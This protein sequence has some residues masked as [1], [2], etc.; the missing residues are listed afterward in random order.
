M[1]DERDIIGPQEYDPW[2]DET[3]TPGFEELGPSHYGWDG[4]PIT[5]RRWA[6]ERLYRPPHVAEEF[7]HVRDGIRFWISTVWI[8]IDHGHRWIGDPNY[9]P[10][11]FETMIFTTT[12]RWNSVFAEING[13]DLQWR[14]ATKEQALHGHTRLAGALRGGWLPDEELPTDVT[15]ECDPD[16]E[17]P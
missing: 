14:W 6:A 5:M 4:E 13:G 3:A 11:I 17:S 1:N 9:R 7:I 10:L 8:G 15:L 12:A 16:Q 2:W